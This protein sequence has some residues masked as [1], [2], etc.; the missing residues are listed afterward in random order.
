MGCAMSEA[1]LASDS[2]TK[3]LWR[4]PLLATKLYV[5]PARA[6]LVSRQRLLEQL[7]QGLAG[8]LILVSAPPGFGKT[9]LVS[10]WIADRGLR[11]AWVSLDESDSDPVRFMGYLIAGLQALAP[12]IGGAAQDLL[13]FPSTPPL[14]SVLTLLIN[15]LCSLP[16]QALL[17]LDD[18][19]VLDTPAIHN[20]VAFL[21]DHLPP[22]LHLVIAT[23]ADPPLPLARWRARGQMAEIRAD[24]LC[25]TTQEA[26]QFFNQAI[27]PRLSAEEVEA[28]DARTEGWIVGLQ[29][30][31]LSMCGR[32]DVSAFV[33]AF[34][35]SHHYVLDYLAEEVL[36]RQPSQI[37]QF[38]LQTSIL[39]RLSGPLCEAITRQ[40][41]GQSLLERL[42]K[43]NLFLVPLDDER[44]W[45]RYH[46]LFAGLLRA[47]LVQTRGAQA[48]EVLHTQAAGWYEASGFPAEAIHHALAAHDHDRAARLIESMCESAW[49]NG[50]FYRLLGWIKALPAELTR[51][52]P[53][54]C[55]W[56]TWTL[57][58]S[59]TVQGVEA[60]IHD[61][62]CMGAAW[63]RSEPA[64][65]LPDTQALMDHIATLRVISASCLRHDPGET[66]KL[67]SQVLELEPAENRKSSLIARCEVLYNVGLAYYLTGE[68]SRAEQTY[69]EVKR[70][71][72]KIGFVLRDI[73]VAHKLALI[74][75]VIGRLHQPYHLYQE[76]LAFIQ[77]QGKQ[78]FFGTGY[79]CCGMSHLL[80]EW[81]CPEEA[82][83]MVAES[84]RLN[85]VA[86]VPHLFIDSYHA[87]ARL[88]IAQQDLN[89]AQTMLQKAA[90][91]IQRHYCW[92]E[93]IGMN[94][95]YQVR[96][97]LANGDLASA[98]RWANGHQLADSEASSF[99]NEWAEIAR[100]RVHIS[101]GLLDEATSLLE[102]LARSAE[103]GGR[104]GRL[105]EILA[106][107]AIA[108]HA[109]GR[110]DAALTALE[111]AL[112][113]AEPEGYVRI[114]L[115]EAAPMADLLQLGCKHGTW[116]AP[117]LVAYTNR[118]L[119][120][121]EQEGQPV[122]RSE[123]S[124]P[125]SGPPPLIEPLSERELE[126]LRLLAEGSSN[127]AIAE[128][129]IVAI[130]TVKAH[131]HSVY[132][133][134]DVRTRTQAIAR[135][136]ELR[137]L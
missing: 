95:S 122:P 41:G 15:E 129:L 103:T 39:D 121:F 49:L 70:I 11:V 40:S 56:Y 118:L 92:P 108:L 77:E 13:R 75:Q 76:T 87:Q 115:D 74:R 93:V 1:G 5:P 90:D 57:L 100:A 96:L 130:G 80:Y 37:Q 136:R 17:V 43:A 68:L 134:L 135:A 21:L 59:G 69:Q 63:L 52:R 23:R 12:G 31:A 66:L 71:A 26:S 78:A 116:A 65:A 3:A 24:D 72:R 4:D 2:A 35:G 60:L 33:R 48:L 53:W 64:N 98:I 29:M 28:L 91:L 123:P 124:V 44:R 111:R 9:T 128:A 107:Q 61:T 119:A 117:W 27:G 81:N 120:A 85:E 127:Q 8:R 97:W 109:Q 22:P 106:L 89:A 34:S 54:L 126:V 99:A 83:Q 62:V 58:Q 36:D 102:R 19:H 101:Q 47:R 14:E 20:A 125:V 104:N 32:E 79:L 110:M 112:A 46:H 30:A 16:G 82:Q 114:F 45:Y 6:N 18:Y 133:K 50:E 73:L 137:L 55:I 113:L 94:E 25:F 42:E 86:Q 84:L 51:N 10:E 67:A 105:I 132:G 131:L 88:L 7:D 38:L